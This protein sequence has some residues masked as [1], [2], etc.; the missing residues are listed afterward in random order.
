MRIAGCLDI[1]HHLLLKRDKQRTYNVTLWRFRVILLPTRLS[2]QPDTMS[3]EEN[4]VME[5]LYC[6]N[7]TYLSSC[8]VPY[9]SI[10][11]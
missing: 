11:F 2:K 6:H 4:A 10:R 1:L 8:R 5:L 3:H 9:I 7:K